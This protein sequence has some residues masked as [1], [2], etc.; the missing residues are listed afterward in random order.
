MR[1]VIFAAAVAALA[2]GQ[3][4][5]DC[6]HSLPKNHSA[7]DRLAIAKVIATGHAYGKHVVTEAQFKA[8]VVKAT[9]DYSMTS[10]PIA[11]K[12]ASEAQKAEAVTESKAA[13][14]GVIQHVMGE[15]ELVCKVGKK[16]DP[17]RRAFY[18]DANNIVVIFNKKDAD[19]GTS[20]R[21]TKAAQ[22]YIEE[23]G[24]GY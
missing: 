6:A 8:G 21:P 15:F 7:A 19:C 1:I 4:S 10:L 13:F 22:T 3:A 20:F 18:D 11:A 12:G 16:V 23:S 9:K 17:E 2:A 24:C 5:A 14:A